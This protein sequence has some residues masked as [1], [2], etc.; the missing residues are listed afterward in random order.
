MHVIIN[1]LADTISLDM[2]KDCKA[3]SFAMNSRLTAGRKS[4]APKSLAAKFAMLGWMVT[5]YPSRVYQ[6]SVLEKRQHE[7]SR[8]SKRPR[9]GHEVPNDTESE[10]YT[11]TDSEFEGCISTVDVR[12]QKRL[13]VESDD[14]GEGTSAKKQYVGEEEALSLHYPS[15]CE[16]VAM[17]KEINMASDKEQGGIEKLLDWHG[18]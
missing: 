16:T 17:S 12:V 13:F 7:G 4:G 11:D 18:K 14:A 3:L 1:F 8:R 6:H 15:A 2:V 10:S 9:R 5:H